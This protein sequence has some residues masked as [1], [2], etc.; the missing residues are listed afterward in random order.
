ME[1]KRSL[2]AG[3]DPILLQADWRGGHRNQTS[4]ATVQAM[5]P[6]APGGWQRKR[7]QAQEPQIT[8]ALTARASVTP[9]QVHAG[10]ALRPLHKLLCLLH[11]P[12]SLSPP[13]RGRC[14][15][16]PLPLAIPCPVPHSLPSPVRK[17]CNE[18]EARV[19]PGRAWPTKWVPDPTQNTD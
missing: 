3:D 16:V 9:R 13:A 12:R 15:G 4:T 17:T 7:Q 14:E 1:F 19:A 2:W 10:H 5:A 11:A 6:G 18:W 8:S